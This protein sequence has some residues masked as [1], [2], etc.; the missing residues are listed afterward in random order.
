LLSPRLD[1]NPEHQ[2]GD[3]EL[4]SRNLR[5]VADQADEQAEQGGDAQ[6]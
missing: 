2:R 4:V 1:A 3:D 5:Q 6:A